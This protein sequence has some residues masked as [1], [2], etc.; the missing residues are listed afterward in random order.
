MIA[1]WC[2][3]TLVISTFS[4]SILAHA[5]SDEALD[6]VLVTATRTPQK[7]GDVLSDNVT[8]SAQQI[9][10]S[11]QTSLV[12]LLQKQRGI[13]ISTYGGPGTTASVFMRG[14]ANN[15][16]VVLIDGVRVGS[17]TTGGAT[18]S[19][20][21][22]SQIDHIEIVYGPLSSFYGADA[23]GGVIQIFTRKGAGT[24]RFNASAGYGSYGTRTMDASVSG[25]TEGDHRFS[26]AIAAAHES[27]DGFS[28]TKPN[29]S[30]YS[31]YDPDKDGYKKDSTS[32]QFGIVLAKGQEVGVTFLQSRLNAQF[33]NGPGFDARTIQKLTDVAVYAKN[34]IVPWWTS[35]LQLSQ[36][37]DKSTNISSDQS[38]GYSEITTTQ[39]NYSWQND[40]LLG[41]DVLQL[42]FERRV[43]EVAA[44]GLSGDRTTNSAAASYQ[45]KRGAH[46]ATISIRND[47]S[48]Q[49]GDHVTGSLGYGYR[50]SKDWR[51]NASYGT[52]FRAPTFNELYYP[53]Y[54]IATNKPEKG[55]NAELGLVYDDGTSQLNVSY[56]R[57]KITD[58]IISTSTCPI[59]PAAYPYGC[60]YNVDKA[61]LEGVSVGASRL[62]GDW[63]LRASMDLQNPRDDTTG[64]LL[65]RRARQHAT[66]A[67]DYGSGAT[68]AGV[69]LVTSG[70]RYDDTDNQTVLGGYSVVN[71]YA[72]YDLTGNWALFGRWNNVF[73]KDY[74]LARYYATAG[75]N[76]FVGVRY[77]FR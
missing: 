37:T 28:A 27:A 10:Q 35:K 29:P 57:N 31:A 8:I 60:A 33:D 5:A 1:P 11:G 15:Q 4:F 56:Y 73:N 34:Q 32:G 77:G 49:F 14:A 48:A 6:P 55:K 16:N 74:E 39:N 50:L 38:Y 52:S 3:S 59:D 71:L 58:L 2:L 40:L 51:A 66:V 61:T 65:P 43:E 44:T 62:L 18:W 7:A 76:L 26:Y 70:K 30:P 69:E 68:K 12:E 72:S 63:A 42:L 46:L 53:G 64:K 25:S 21:P 41:P 13:E 67:L 22:L 54:G 45:L 47:N 23:I 20:I 24:S 36:T 9:A 19:S 17:S 75:S